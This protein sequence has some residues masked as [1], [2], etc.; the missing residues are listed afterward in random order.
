MGFDLF[1]QIIIKQSAKIQNIQHFIYNE[2]K[3]PQKGF[4]K[5]YHPVILQTPT[6]WKQLVYCG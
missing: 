5:N 2:I 1:R 3:L 6:Q 4:I